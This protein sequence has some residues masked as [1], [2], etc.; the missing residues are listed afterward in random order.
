VAV[1]FFR[2]APVRHCVYAQTTFTISAKV[3][4]EL[5]LK[6]DRSPYLKRRFLD[7]AD[8]GLADLLSL[9]E[10]NVRRVAAE[11]ACGLIFSENDLVAVGEDLYRVFFADLHHFADLDGKHDS[12]KVVHLSYYT[13]RFHYLF[14]L[15]FWIFC[16]FRLFIGK[17]IITLPYIS[18]QDIFRNNLEVFSY[19]FRQ[20][21]TRG[22][23]PIKSGK[24]SKDQ[25][26][27]VMEERQNAVSD[28]ISTTGGIVNCHGGA[29]HCLPIIGQ[30]EGHYM[31]GDKQK[32]TKYEQILPLLA[33]IE[34]SAEVGG[35]LLLINTMGGDVEAGLAMAEM[36][37]SMKKP[38]VSLVLGG[39][40]SIGI[41]LAVAA[42]RCV[43]V[44]SATMTV[45]PV[46][47]SGLVIGSWQSV[48]YFKEMQGRVNRFIC[49]HSRIAEEK[50]N[51]LM[52]ARDDMANDTGS[53]IGG[54][55]AVRVGLADTLGGL[56]EALE[57][58]AQMREQ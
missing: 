43:I 31:L 34:E 46:R 47:I 44:P 57:A 54:E 32:T 37:A 27:A 51:E 15:C 6:S 53:V 17:Y 26:G 14:L 18:C 2:N 12:S 36:V 42:K 28:G 56:S 19:K 24:M 49:D 39:G 1:V 11:N 33:A 8:A 50:L 21:T 5:F 9:K 52:Y 29:V 38:T 3:F 40:H 16:F 45:H 48:K 25:G 20:I 55:E 30:I 41:P 4:A 10:G 23:K 58:L 22:I 35:L 7:L 13:C